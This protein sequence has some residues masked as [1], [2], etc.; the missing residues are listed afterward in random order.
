M[1]TLLCLLFIP[2][3]SFSQE[4]LLD[5][6]DKS[7]LDPTHNCVVSEQEYDFDEVKFEYID[8]ARDGQ[9]DA[10]AYT[11]SFFDSKLISGTVINKRL[12]S[13]TVYLEGVIQCSKSW[14]KNGRIKSESYYASGFY[15]GKH[16]DYNI[17]GNI[18]SEV[19]YDYG[20]LH[21]Y[22]INW[23][24]NGRLMNKVRYV[25][26]KREGEY[27]AY[28][29]NGN[30]EEKGNYYFDNKEGQWIYYNPNGSIKGGYYY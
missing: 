9:S 5:Y 17:D 16:I 15:H 28:H 11:N 2:I 1:K 3:L 4:N 20:K 21:G 14:W 24:D 26:N 6:A 7:L 10:I 12:G 27:V 25:L 13:K 29:Q 18:V 22:K 30:M 19:N 8:N 23:Y